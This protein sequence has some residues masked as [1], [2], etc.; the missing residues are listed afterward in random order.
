MLADERAVFPDERVQVIGL[1]PASSR[2]PLAPELAESARAF[3]GLTLVMGHAPEFMLSA[4]E[5][6]VPLVLLAGHTHGGQ[7]VLP[8]LG[9][10]L[11]LARV[12]RRL[13]RGGLHRIGESWAC[14]SRGIGME[15]GHAPR[16]RFLCRPELV[17]IDLAA[18]RTG[19]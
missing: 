11:T 6:D 4:A 17:V 14:V 7:V 12:P 16:I 13:A 18:A 19:E 9:P 15:R 1:A 2:R 5:L 3:D 8:L 10:P